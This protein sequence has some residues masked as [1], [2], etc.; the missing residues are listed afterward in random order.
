MLLEKIRQHAGKLMLLAVSGLLVLTGS[1]WLDN[2]NSQQAFLERWKQWSAAKMANEVSGQLLDSTRLQKIQAE[3]QKNRTAILESIANN[4]DSVATQKTVVVT[5][6][7]PGKT[8]VVEVPV[9]GST[10][11]AT[12]KATTTKTS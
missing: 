7:I 9:T 2:R 12:K 8:R 6:T 10:K 4:P 3:L 1:L 11:S 5:K